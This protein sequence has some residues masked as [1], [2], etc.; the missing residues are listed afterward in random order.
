MSPGGVI[1][2][3]DNWLARERT[4]HPRTRAFLPLRGEINP[5][6]KF[7]LQHPVGIEA[8]IQ[9]TIGELPSEINSQI[10]Y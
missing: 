2:H 5:A 9:N 10:V 7:V 4:L 3:G 6:R 1:A 8:G